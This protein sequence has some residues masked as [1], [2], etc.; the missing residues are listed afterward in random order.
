MFAGTPEFAVAP[1]EALLTSGHRVVAV[2]TQPDRPA[3]R[4]RKLAASP[5]KQ[6]ALQAGLPVLQPNS[7]RPPGEVAQLASLQPDVMVVVAYGLILPTAILAVPRFGCLNIHA[8]LLPRWRGA[9]PIQRAIQAGDRETGITIMQMDKGLD[10]GP[11]LSRSACPIDPSDTAQTLHDRLS[12]MGSEPL[13]GVLQS[14]QNG[15]LAP[16][17]QDASQA[18]YAAKL[19]KAESWLDWGLAAVQL[20]QTVRAFNPWPVARTLWGELPLHIWQ[21]RALSGVA[22]NKTMPGTVVAVAKEG[23]DVATG[24][25]VLRLLELQAPGGRR[26]PA[27]DFLNAHRIAVG[28]VLRAVADTSS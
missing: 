21:V 15:T 18:T 26:L 24:E 3:G 28:A 27:A 7:L 25:G 20:A 14:I 4:G 5:V 1:L 23:V 13:L 19:D 17:A 12:A 10:T 11:M 2:Y 16:L 22:A 8:S 6:R 9:A